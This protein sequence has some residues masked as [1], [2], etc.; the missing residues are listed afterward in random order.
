[1]PTANILELFTPYFAT[2]TD[3]RMQRSQRHSLLDILTIAMCATLANADSWVD[4][5]RFGNAKIAFFR[6]FLELPHG[7]PSHDTFGRVFGKIDPAALLPC[8]QRWLA[9]LRAA[10]ERES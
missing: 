1:M 4:V 10:I 3:P 6:R 7:I 2:L 5:E 9:A 8:V